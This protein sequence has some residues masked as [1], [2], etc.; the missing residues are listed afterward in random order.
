MVVFQKAVRNKRMNA[1]NKTRDV[2]KRQGRCSG[3][4]WTVIF[5]KVLLRCQPLRSEVPAFCSERCAC[6]DRLLGVRIHLTYTASSLMHNVH[7][8][9][10]AM[11]DLA[12]FQ[13][14]AIRSTLCHVPKR[15]Y[16]RTASLC[17][18]LGFNPSPLVTRLQSAR[19]SWVSSSDPQNRFTRH[20]I[21]KGG[22]ERSSSLVLIVFLPPAEIRPPPWRPDLAM[23]PRTENNRSMTRSRCAACEVIWINGFAMSVSLLM[24]LSA[25]RRAKHTLDI[26][27][28]DRLQTRKPR[29]DEITAMRDGPLVFQDER[30]VFG[31]SASTGYG[32]MYHAFYNKVS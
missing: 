9:W 17:Y 11:Y 3:I 28:S 20:Q 21:H 23:A 5:G 8:A 14:I 12:T 4:A 2:Y 10:A 24:A 7:S 15:L 26:L 31:P 6:H 30:G 13:T 1:M 22:K 18:D 19:K 32:T 29:K 27:I 16:R 25:T